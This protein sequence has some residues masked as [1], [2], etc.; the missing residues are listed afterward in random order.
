L[1]STFITLLVVFFA[2]ACQARELERLDGAR[3]MAYGGNDGDSFKIKYGNK[4]QIIRLYYVDCPE[5]YAT[6]DADDRRVR[7]QARHFGLSDK[8]HIF[9]YGKEASRFTQQQLAKPFTVHTAYAD[10]LG[11][12]AGG[13]VYG[14]VT[15]A[16]GCDLAE[17]LI[18]NGYA[19][20]HGVR[21]ALPDGTHRDEV[22]ARLSDKET[23]AALKKKGIWA[24]T[25][26]DRLV[27]LRAASRLEEAELKA[28]ENP[29]VIGIININAATSQELQSIKGVGPATAAR[30]I[31]LRPFKTAADLNRIPRIPKKTKSNIAELVTF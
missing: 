11:R 31:D 8:K 24:E 23:V 19:R 27:A 18:E 21:R 13:R 3:L 28:T 20:N 25:D 12:S 16:D 9:N 4:E 5:S 29:P 26:P 14:F 10:A 2:L 22:Q 6:T 1:K 17:L 15:T 7:E 30:I